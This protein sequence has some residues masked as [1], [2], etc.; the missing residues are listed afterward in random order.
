MNG[1]KKER[2]TLLC[3][4]LQRPQQQIIG[5]STSGDSWVFFYGSGREKME[6]DEKG[7]LVRG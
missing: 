3:S 2:F 6:E 5:K 4:F 1:Q 7:S